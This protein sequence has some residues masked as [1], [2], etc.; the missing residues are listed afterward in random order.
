VH[1][2]LIE[3]LFRLVKACKEYYRIG[4]QQ[5]LPVDT[6]SEFYQATIELI[7]ACRSFKQRKAQLTLLTEVLGVIADSL[8]NWK[9]DDTWVCPLLR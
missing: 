3:V 5:N 9:T 7:S 8:T 6:V 2:V 1:W 4:L